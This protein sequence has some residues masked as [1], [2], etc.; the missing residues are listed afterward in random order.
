MSACIKPRNEQTDDSSLNCLT[1]FQTVLDAHEYAHHKVYEAA[2]PWISNL[3]AVPACGGCS[4]WQNTFEQT[5]SRSKKKVTAR[6]RIKRSATMDE[7]A[8][9]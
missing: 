4:V 1:E 5:I 7:T 8:K 6:I 9:L 3:C 2:V